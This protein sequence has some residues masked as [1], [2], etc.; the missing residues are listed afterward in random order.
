MPSVYTS[1]TYT[2]FTYILATVGVKQ[3]RVALRPPRSD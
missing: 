2:S 1:S 3:L